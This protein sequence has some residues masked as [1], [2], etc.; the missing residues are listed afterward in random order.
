MDQPKVLLMGLQD[1][2]IEPTPERFAETM[3]LLAN[4]RSL[5]CKMGREA[6]KQSKKYDWANF[7]EKIDRYIDS[8]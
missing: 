4:D 2:L 8:L 6:R 1:F 7:V 5:T 3:I